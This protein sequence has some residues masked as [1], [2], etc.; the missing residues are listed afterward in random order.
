MNFPGAN[1][2][3]D[4]MFRKAEG[5]VWD[6]MT[7]KIG[8]QSDSGIVTLEGEGDDA[9][10]NINMLDEFGVAL[11]AFA[12]S[13]PVDQINVGD[14]IY[15]GKRD[16]VRFVT[17]VVEAAKPTTK[18]AKAAAAAAVSPVKKFRVMSLDGTSSTWTPP[19]ATILGF[20]SGV[21]VL[22]S[23]MSLLPN[24]QNGLNEIQS[25][26]GM[27]MQMQLL[28]GGDADLDFERIMPMMLMSMTMQGGQSGG[29]AMGGM[30]QAMMMSQ[31]FSNRDGNAK[32]IGKTKSNDGPFWR[33]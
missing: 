16:T 29:N 27:M 13:T 3:M 5:V 1:K 33:G 11:P 28:S 24:G 15:T 30:M 4:R 10:V 20:D 21:M 7:G 23:L 8:I 9:R 6:M 18:T 25:S 17:G 22:R 26:I 32:A 14:I 2:F 19:K 31:M 12:Q